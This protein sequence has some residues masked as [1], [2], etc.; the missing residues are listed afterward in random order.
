MKTFTFPTRRIPAS[1]PCDEWYIV[2]C[3]YRGQLDRKKDALIERIAKRSGETGYWF[4][5][6][7]IRDIGFWY[8]QPM[9]AILC[10]ARLQ[11]EKLHKRLPGVFIRHRIVR[12]PKYP[13][14]TSQRSRYHERRTAQTRR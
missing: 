2:E 9:A 11:S 14:S 6:G 8:K 1:T 13:P 10:R 12:I 4:G 7:G 5:N 3:W